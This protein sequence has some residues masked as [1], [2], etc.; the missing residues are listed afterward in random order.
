MKSCNIT[1]PNPWSRFAD[2]PPAASIVKRRAALARE[3]YVGLAPHSEGTAAGGHRCDQ[4]SMGTPHHWFQA[5]TMIYHGRRAK[6][7]AQC[8]NDYAFPASL[9]PRLATTTDEG[10]GLGLLPLYLT[11]VTSIPDTAKRKSTP[12]PTPVRLMTTPL[13][14]C[15]VVAPAPPPTA[16]PAAALTYFPS[17]SANRFK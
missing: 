5:C 9:L 11:S 10:R 8:S 16:I 1:R 14:F 7:A 3:S 4:G 6:L 15:M 12:W 2:A 13:S 17:K